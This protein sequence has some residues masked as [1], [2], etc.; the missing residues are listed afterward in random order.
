MDGTL[1][2]SNNEPMFCPCGNKATG[3]IMGKESYKLWCSACTIDSTLS[4]DANF[5]Y[6][7][8]N[9]HEWKNTQNTK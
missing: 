6:E 5:I 8:T 4:V 7:P 9:E 3:G 2:D 1:Y